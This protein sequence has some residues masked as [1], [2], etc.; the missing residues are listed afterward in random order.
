MFIKLHYSFSCL[1][2]SPTLLNM[3]ASENELNEVH[4]QF[5]LSIMLYVTPKYVLI[6]AMTASLTEL[7][8]TSAMISDD[9]HSSRF[10][11]TNHWCLSLR[12]RLQLLLFNVRW[13]L[14]V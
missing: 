2:S 7:Y 6:T 1:I 10:N 13:I 4:Q 9:R 5:M 8:E 12:N 3:F 11:K 14:H